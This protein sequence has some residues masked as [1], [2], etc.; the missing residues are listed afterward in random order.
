MRFILQEGLVFFTPSTFEKPWHACWINWIFHLSCDM[1][2]QENFS[3]CIVRAMRLAYKLSIWTD[4]F[5]NAQRSV[6]EAFLI[7]DEKTGDAFR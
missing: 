5:C 3:M 6:M 4:S 1:L 2:V 7:L